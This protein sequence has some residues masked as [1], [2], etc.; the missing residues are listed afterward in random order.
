MVEST[1]T[2]PNFI[3]NICIIT[4]FVLGL[5]VVMG[6]F[7]WRNRTCMVKTKYGEQFTVQNNK[8]EPDNIKYQVADRLSLLASKTDKLVNHMLVNNI[9]NKETAELLSHRWANI[10]SSSDGFRETSKNENTAAYTVNKHEQLRICVRTKQ[11]PYML[12]NENT[13]MFVM[14]HEL[15]HMMSKSYG[16][17]FEF[18]KN[19]A[20]ITKVAVDMGLYKYEDFATNP[21]QFCGVD[22]SNPAYR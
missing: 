22:I 13:T 18:R 7:S 2:N 16:H 5:F 15:A 6:F 4:L 14:L 3:Y 12:E 10:R 8:N 1:T 19:F 17:N 21:V 9:P 20:T 11:D